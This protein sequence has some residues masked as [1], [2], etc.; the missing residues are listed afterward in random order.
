MIQVS[1][2]PWTVE[3]LAT[4]VQNLVKIMTRNG[5]IELNNEQS[6]PETCLHGKCSNNV[7]CM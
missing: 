7:K 1:L 6:L 5:N 4:K 3:A 2:R